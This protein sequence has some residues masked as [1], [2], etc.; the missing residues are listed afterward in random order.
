M[1]PLPDLH[2]ISLPTPLPVGPV[3][4]Y[5][6]EGGQLTLIDTGPK[7]DASR[8]ALEAGL[9]G[10]GY[11]VEDLRRVVLTHRHVDHVGLAGEI[12][13]RSGAQVVTHPLT[14]PW[15]AGYSAE[16]ERNRA[17]YQQIWREGGVPAEIVDEISREGGRTGRWVD[18]LDPAS[19]QTVDEGDRLCLA[20]LEWQ[21]FHTPGHAGGLICLWQPQSRVL[22]AN[23]H[24]IRKISSNPVIE[25]PPL[26]Y[27]ARPR[28]LVEYLSHMQRMA[29][30]KPELALS[31]HGEAITDP[32]GLV[33]QRL[34]F[35]RRR[36]NLVYKALAD[37]PR[38]LWELTAP[39]FPRLRNGT[40]YV[41]GMSEILGHL[42]LLVEDGRVAPVREGALLRW[43]RR[44]G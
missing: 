33:R 40:D 5:L 26:S 14:V 31:G 4:V 9:A 29:A 24:L 12:V 37:G 21:V 23:D 39:I 2:L 11:C 22:L 30:L 8:A 17:F 16:L 41:L 44:P 25:H 32:A 1:V 3:N 27:G 15:L 6:A 7:H 43:S 35:H 19:I 20:G 34:A 36:A 13:A 38:T 28:R 18:S 42:D 10:H